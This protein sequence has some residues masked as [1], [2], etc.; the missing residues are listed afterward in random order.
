MLEAPWDAV[1]ERPGQSAVRRAFF[2]ENGQGVLTFIVDEQTETLRIIDIL[3][4]VNGLVLLSSLLLLP[5]Y[6]PGSIPVH[7]WWLKLPIGRPHVI[8]IGIAGRRFATCRGSSGPLAS[9]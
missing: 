2:G 6:K 3:C 7:R 5:A 4:W 9:G 1:A 8:I